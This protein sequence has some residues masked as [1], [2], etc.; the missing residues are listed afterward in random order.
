MRHGGDELA[1]SVA[2]QLGVGIERN[3][4]LDAFQV[5]GVA[6][7]QCELVARA[8]AQVAVHVLQLAALALIPHPHAFLRIP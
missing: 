1:R 6:H 5:G 8:A 3:D 2:R 4:V 7:G